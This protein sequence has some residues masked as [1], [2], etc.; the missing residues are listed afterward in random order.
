MWWFV[1]T[2]IVLGGAVALLAYGLGRR[3]HTG[4]FGERL[5]EESRN[6]DK[7]GFG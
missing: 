7:G 2:I 1:G 3:G 4:G 5:S 6:K